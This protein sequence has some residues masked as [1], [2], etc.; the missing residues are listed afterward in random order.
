MQGLCVICTL[1]YIRLTFS[2]PVH[3]VAERPSRPDGVSGERGS[4]AGQEAPA[5]VPSLELL[6][7]LGLPRQQLRLREL[8]HGQG[9]LARGSVVRAMM[10]TTKG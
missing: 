10:V 1:V 5:G 3:R 9:A 8:R 6:L 4:G 7:Q 2:P